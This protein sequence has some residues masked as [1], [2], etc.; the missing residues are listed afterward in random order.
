VAEALLEQTNPNRRLWRNLRF[1]RIAGALLVA[2]LPFA[3]AFVL[4][5]FVVFDE[6]NSSDLSVA[7]LAL[8]YALNFIFIAICTGIHLI[9]TRIRGFATRRQCFVWGVL[10]SIFVE[11]ICLGL[12]IALTPEAE[13]STTGLM[14]VLLAAGV[15]GL[16]FLPAGLLSGWIYWRLGIRPES[17]PR[18]NTR[19]DP[20]DRMSLTPRHRRWRDLRVG[21]ILLGLAI[22]PVIVTVL[23]T[24]AWIFD[25]EMAGEEI[26]GATIV[27]LILTTVYWQMGGWGY[28]LAV[29]RPRR[30]IMRL[31]CL[32]ISL[33]L[34]DLL[35]P[36]LLMFVFAI[37][38]KQGL[39]NMFGGRELSALLII[40]VLAAAAI[41]FAPVGLL[42][43][44]LFWRI[45]VRPAAMPEPDVGAVFD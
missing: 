40:V 10:T 30:R 21:R 22:A 16:L 44:W 13:Q 38:G 24:L 17:Q 37:E 19:P 14:P 5:A 33:V 32:L 43:G 12:P 2:T 15:G 39:I 36:L 42:N 28:L 26:I 11:V 35:L 27:V 41:L 3:T 25:G 29:T 31:E 6:D 8:F 1:L 34:T 9:L 7:E 45:G 18:A 20:V 23:L 4:T